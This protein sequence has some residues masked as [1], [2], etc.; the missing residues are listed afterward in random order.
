MLALGLGTAR[1]V[2]FSVS[3]TFCGQSVLP[4]VWKFNSCGVEGSNGSNQVDLKNIELRLQR[5]VHSASRDSSI[6]A[7]AFCLTRA[8]LRG[9]EIG[10]ISDYT[11]RR[12][13]ED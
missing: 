13:Y 5:V 1:G 4:D 8:H 7:D 6:Q 10:C 9:H 3:L 11:R 2:S 12:I